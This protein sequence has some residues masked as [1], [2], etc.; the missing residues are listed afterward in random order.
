MSAR[1]IG[2]YLKIVFTLY[3]KACLNVNIFLN[4]SGFE[5]KIL[6][7]MHDKLLTNLTKNFCLASKNKQLLCKNHENEMF[8]S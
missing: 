1:S 8:N 5:A 2:N 4:E 7:S 6:K 3:F